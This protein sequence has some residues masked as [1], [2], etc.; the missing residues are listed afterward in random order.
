MRFW[1]Q[2]KRP[3][4]YRVLDAGL[5]RVG[6]RIVGTH[7]PFEG[8]TRRR[9]EN[10]TVVA[11]PSAD[12]LG[13]KGDGVAGQEHRRAGFGLEELAGLETGL[14]GEA[15]V[16]GAAAGGDGDIESERLGGGREL[17]LSEERVIGKGE[18]IA[19]IAQLEAAA[20]REMV[21]GVTAA[22]GEGRELRLAF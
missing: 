16:A 10:P 17:E 14:Q 15:A 12:L 22:L 1:F 7:G 3:Y 21:L 5:G 11:D 13:L 8:R 19:G 20:E 9:V 2:R 6:V 18:T 4:A